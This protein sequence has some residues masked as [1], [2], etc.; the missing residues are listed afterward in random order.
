[1]KGYRHLK[2]EDRL[3][4][5]NLLN[6][7]MKKKEI[8]K[9]L[10]C[11]PNTITN[12]LKRGMYLHRNSDYTEEWRYSPELA[13]E[14]Y[15]LNVSVRGTGLKISNDYDYARYLEKKIVDED[16]SPAAVLG[17]LNETGQEKE[18]KTRI[19]VTTLYSYI[20]KGIFF[21]L[22]N[23]D[24]PVKRKK[25]RKYRHIKRQKRASA[26]KSI[27][28]RPKKIEKRE[29]FGH[30]E[31]DTVV[32]KRG[33]SKNS[34]LV[35]TERKTRK[36][37]LFKLPSHEASEVV[38]KIDELEKLWKDDFKKV[39]KSITVD[40]GTEFS[41]AEEMEKSIYGGKRTEVYYCHAFSSWE[42]GSNENQNRLVRRKVPKGSNFDHMTD[43]E[44]KAVEN[45]MNHYPRKLFGWRTAEQ[46]FQKELAFIT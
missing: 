25:K 30:W 1:M 10:C 18:F 45:W 21:S 40:N 41:Y 2:Y 27:A 34:L 6:K 12:E 29:E 26:G 19:C 42:R 31:M 44:V 4:L 16:Y 8:A 28:K 5:E 9:G 7:K 38:K 46:Q 37:I 11:H 14:K 32:G 13:E 15:Q 20:D 39:F 17:E 33:V 22:T 43:E 35:L 3:L 36:E 23:K 24:L